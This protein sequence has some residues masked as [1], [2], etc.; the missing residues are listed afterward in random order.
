MFWRVANSSG[1]L[2]VIGVWIRRLN[3][4]V[5]GLSHQSQHGARNILWIYTEPRFRLL[6]RAE[7]GLSN[8]EMGALLRFGVGMIDRSSERPIVLGPGLYVARH[9]RRSGAGSGWSLQASYSRASFRGF[10]QLGTTGGVIPGSH[11]VTFGVG[12]YQ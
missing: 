10:N 12:W 3:M 2:P 11:K 6:G 9:I 1:R 5:F 7:P 8:W 4:C